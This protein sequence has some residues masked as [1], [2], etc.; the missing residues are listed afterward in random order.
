M[1]TPKQVSIGVSKLDDE[2]KRHRRKTAPVLT[3]ELNSSQLCRSQFSSNKFQ[4]VRVHYTREIFPEFRS[5]N[6]GVRVIYIYSIDACLRPQVLCLLIK[7]I[8]KL[9]KKDIGEIEKNRK[10]H[11]RFHKYLWYTVQKKKKS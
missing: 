8:I 4:K 6:L 1:E 3:A 9:R 10:I 2:S 7:T 11:V 5:S